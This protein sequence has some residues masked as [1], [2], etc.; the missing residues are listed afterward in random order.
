MHNLRFAAFAGSWSRP[1]KTRALVDEAARRAAT[2]FG[3]SAHVFDI[4][5]LGA[6]FAVPGAANNAL[7]HHMQAVLDADALIVA[8]PVYKG[9]YTGL[10][11]HFFDLIDP[12]ALVGKPVLLAATGGGDRHALMIEHQMRP[13][14]GFFEAKALATGVY[15]SATD[16]DGD[17]IAPGA[18]SD[19]LDRA[20]AQFSDHLPVRAPVPLRAAV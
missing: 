2:S 17:R 12:A 16:F 6:D 8:S 10:F 20:L 5:D 4:G 15:L 14:F 13:L 9:S 11:K 3:G 19:R 1:S 7:V 18:A